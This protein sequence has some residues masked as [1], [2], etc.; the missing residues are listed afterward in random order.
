M[1]R[2]NG[3]SGR[4]LLWLV[5]LMVILVAALDGLLYMGI[6]IMVIKAGE[7]QALAGGMAFQESLDS[8]LFIKPWFLKA[9]VPG[10]MALALLFSMIFYFVL[11][12]IV[13]LDYKSPDAATTPASGKAADPDQ[14]QIEEKAK[15]RLFVH[16][17]S[18]LQSEGRLLDFFSEKMD[19][20]DDAQIGAAVRHIHD[21]CSRTLDKYLQLEPVMDKAEGETV[22]I[23]AGFDPS[24]VKLTGDVVGNP[25]FTGILRHKGWKA[26]KLDIPKLS[27]QANPEIL[28]PAEVE[29]KP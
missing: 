1:D 4:F 26:S 9:F 2:V 10:T 12:Y 23:E 15:A 22:T 28:A 27:Q 3:M 8:F 6:N 13:R 19:G 16:L 7:S 14:E 17:L 20:Y 29:I 21:Q 5:F 11:G 18:V 24:V 25:P